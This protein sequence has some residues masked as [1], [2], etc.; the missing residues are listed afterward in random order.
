MKHI[1]KLLALSLIHI[2]LHGGGAAAG[3]LQNVRVKLVKV[4][5]LCIRD[6]ALSNLFQ[7]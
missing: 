4:G 5:Q 1:K 2:F 3:I 6:R 7:S